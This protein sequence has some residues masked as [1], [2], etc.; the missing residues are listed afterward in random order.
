MAVKILIKHKFKN[1]NMRA[2]SRFLINNRTGAMQQPGYISSET[3]R[4]LDDQDQVMVVSMWENMEA[5][6]A[7]KNS[8][9]RKANVAEFKDYLA[10]ETVY[11]HYSLGLPFE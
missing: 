6:G 5:W 4:S 9:T 3:L 11:E 10:G 7:W 8:E 2:A 1:G